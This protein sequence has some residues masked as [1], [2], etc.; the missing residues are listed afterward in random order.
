MFT[1]GKTVLLNDIMSHCDNLEDF[2]NDIYTKIDNQKDRWSR[3]VAEILEINHYSQ[4]DLARLCDVSRATVLKWC[5]GSLPQ[6]REAFIKIGFAA[7]LD[8]KEMNRFL[9]RYGRYPELY[10]K[11]PEDSIYIFVLNSTEIEHTYEACKAVFEKVEMYLSP[12]NREVQLNPSNR[13]VQLNPSNHGTDLHPSDSKEAGDYETVKVM[14]YLLSLSE[15]KELK[16][17]LE[18]SSDMFTSSF[19]KFYDY[20]KTF[21]RKNNESYMDGDNPDNINLLADTLGWSSSLRKCVYSIYK[22]EWFP[23]R[24]KVISLGIHL[25]MNTDEI[26]TMLRLA[27][28]EPLYIVNPI[29]C[30]II[31]AVLEAELDEE[32]YD[33]TDDLYNHVLDV[34]DEMGIEDDEIISL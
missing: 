33:G 1:S 31:Y 5:R 8:L 21:V 7:H 28:M 17:F 26:N 22:N 15:V 13:E 16:E 34:F 11:T 25:N 4:A 24:S 30:I 27:K 19:E 12:S 3:K 2:K 10:P 20:V 9:Q 14:E 6:S 29:E 18:S 32:I 23:L